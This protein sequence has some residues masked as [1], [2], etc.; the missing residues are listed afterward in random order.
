MAWYSHITEFKPSEGTI[1]NYIDSLDFYL[2][3]NKVTE[4]SK[5]RTVLQTVVGPQQF[6]LPKDLAAPEK[7]ADK[8]YDALCLLLNQHH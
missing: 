4:V 1:N 5:K 8:T 7:P 6:R 3:A 2:E